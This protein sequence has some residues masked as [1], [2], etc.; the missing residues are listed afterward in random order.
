M[1]GNYVFDGGTVR[2]Q[3]VVRRALAASSFDWGVVRARVTI[4]IVPCG[5]AGATK[6]EITLD[7]ADLVRGGRGMWGIVQH[8]Y[9]HQVDFAL[10]TH[11][12]R[13]RFR[14]LLRTRRWCDE[15]SGAEHAA[16]GCE[17]FASTLA[18]A[19][20]QSP[21]NYFRPLERADEAGVVSPARFRA[22]LATVLTR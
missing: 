14:R 8:E 20:W 9:A 13:R 10:F 21:V 17:R 5:C 15:A 1:G 22:A 2:Q 7:G 11:S 12:D 19:F 18:W 4:H 16:Y 3:S 6:G